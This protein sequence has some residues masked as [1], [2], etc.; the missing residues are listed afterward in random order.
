MGKTQCPACGAAVGEDAALCPVCG[1]E[2]AETVKEAAPETPRE[3]A[4]R[5]NFY[6]VLVVVLVV[7]AGA[8]LLLS[9]G[10]LPNPFRGLVGGTAAVVNGQKITLAEL[11]EKLEVAKKMS[12]K[13]QGDFSSPQG[14]RVLS[15]MR[16]K[17]L[18]NLIQ[19]R[20]IVTE[21]K[22]EGITVSPQEVA[23]RMDSIRQG[24]NL[25][26]QDFEAF[27]RNHNVTK[28]S[29]EKRVEKDLLLT[30]LVEKGKEKGLGQDEVLKEINSRAKVEILIK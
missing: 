30:K 11:D 12:M 7:V 29:F 20:I 21:A 13:G 2:V 15:E 8:A 28:A 27:L 6:A 24:L 16:M 25:S 17:I 3:P 22:K 4:G 9:A 14:K 26:E 5:K 19:E 23:S 18:H 10:I 1:R